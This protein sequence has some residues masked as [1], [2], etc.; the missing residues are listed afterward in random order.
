MENVTFIFSDTGNSLYSRK[1]LGCRVFFSKCDP[2]RCLTSIEPADRTE[3]GEK[4]V[5]DR[6]RLAYLSR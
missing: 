4:A 5:W 1:T 2:G 6:R 3:A